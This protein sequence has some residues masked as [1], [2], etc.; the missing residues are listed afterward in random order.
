MRKPLVQVFQCNSNISITIMRRMTERSS[1]ADKAE[2]SADINACPYEKVNIPCR[3]RLNAV[4]RMRDARK[5][6][7]KRTATPLLERH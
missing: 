6:Y 1:D 3:S 4:N 7:D 5:D 2:R